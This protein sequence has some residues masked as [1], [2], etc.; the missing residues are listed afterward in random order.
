MSRKV[1]CWDNA[2]VKSFIGTLKH[3]LVFHQRY[4]SRAKAKQSIFEYIERFYNR[5]RL[6][7]TLGYQ[8]PVYYEANHFKLAA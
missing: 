3:E 6:H 7:S 4:Y 1:D 2:P 5:K 8:S